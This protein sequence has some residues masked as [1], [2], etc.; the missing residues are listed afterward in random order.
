MLAGTNVF[1]KWSE[2]HRKQT[3]MNHID[4][5]NR[6]DENVEM[7]T[8]AICRFGIGN[9]SMVHWVRCILNCTTIAVTISSE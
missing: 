9:D 8:I 3:A 5:K 7:I 2:S 6:L 1:Y 4:D